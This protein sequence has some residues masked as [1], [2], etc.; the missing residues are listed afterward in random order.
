MIRI[1]RVAIE[2]DVG[3]IAAEFDLSLCRLAARLARA[4]QLTGDEGIPV[5][6]MRRDVIHHVRRR[7]DAALESGSS[8]DS[9][10][11]PT[12]AVVFTSLDGSP[13]LPSALTLQLMFPGNIRCN[14]AG[15]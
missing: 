10:R 4:L 1:S 11:R 8:S 13:H 7:D 14:G 5:A 6:V 15:Q 12:I 2:P 9:A 3:P